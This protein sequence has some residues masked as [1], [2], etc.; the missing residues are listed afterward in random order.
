MSTALV[1][2]GYM[3]LTAVFAFAFWRYGDHSWPGTLQW[4]LFYWAAIVQPCIWARRALH[5]SQ[6]RGSPV[7]KQ[8]R[9]VAYYIIVTGALV[10]LVGLSLVR[11]TALG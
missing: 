6:D 7:A 8:L 3:P 9:S 2:A 11:S 10:L 4:A 1:V 5:W